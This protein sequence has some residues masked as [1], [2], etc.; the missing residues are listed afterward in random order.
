MKQDYFDSDLEIMRKRR[1]RKRKM[2]KLRK[3]LLSITGILVIG[4]AAFFVTINI[5]NPEFD[6]SGIMSERSIRVVSH[7]RGIVNGDSGEKKSGGASELSTSAT[8]AAATEPD[9]YDYLDSSCFTFDADKKGNFVGNVLNGG[10]IA[11]SP[12][13]IYNLANNKGIYRFIPSTEDYAI[14]YPSDDILTCLNLVG[15]YLYY[16]NKNDGCLYSLERGTS[17]ARKLDENVDF[18]Y[19]YDKDAYYVSGLNTMCYMDLK[20]GSAKQL[21]KSD[22]KLRFIGISLDRVFFAEKNGSSVTYL[23]V[24]KHDGKQAQPFMA[25]TSSQK[26]KY[27]S[28]ENGFLYYYLLGD[29]GDYDLMRKK[30]GSDRAVT[31]LKNV[32][33]LCYPVVDANKLYYATLKDGKY[34]MR[35]YN[36]N[37]KEKKTMLS[38]SGVDDSAPIK[39][40]HGG[41]YDFIIGRKSGN[42][43]IVYIASDMYTSSENIMRFSKGEWRY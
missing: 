24:D 43:D 9:Y 22:G 5:V 26:I 40:Y 38:V 1:R 3:T 6:F 37:T 31:L 21:Y 23:S 12:S 30:F 39:I 35:E 13:Y 32:E 2:K 41:E 25:D 11:K 34:R 29:D 14:S 36:M 18:V 19:V 20:T 8:T 7:I 27:M 17:N 15:E 33:P 42:G 4:I 28:M 16:I 10:K